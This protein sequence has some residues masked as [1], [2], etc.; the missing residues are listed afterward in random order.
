MTI[1]ERFLKKTNKTSGCWEWTAFISNG[2]GRFGFGKKVEYAHRV[3][4]MLFKGAI[5]AGLYVCHTC[6]NRRCVNPSHL[7]LGTAKDN[8]QD[9]MKKGRQKFGINYKYGYYLSP[10]SPHFARSEK[11]Q[12]A[13]LKNYQVRSIRKSKLPLLNLALKYDVHVSTISR[14]KTGI[15]FRD[16]E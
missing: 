7:F 4:W 12:S 10:D 2:Y 14:V 1:V 15:S 5:P 16:V 9:M 6:D 8:T 11:H 3:S 13:K